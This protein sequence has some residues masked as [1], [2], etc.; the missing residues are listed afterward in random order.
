MLL[1][2]AEV[3]NHLKKGK[4]ISFKLPDG[5]FIPEYFHVTEIGKITKDFIDC[6]GTLRSQKV[7]NFQFWYSTDYNHRLHPK[8]LLHIIKL[9]K[10]KLHIDDGL[11]I[12]VEYQK[13][14]T[15][16]KYML[17]HDGI[18]FVLLTQRT[19]C[20]AKSDCSIESKQED[21]CCETSKVSCC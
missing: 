5:D 9:S 1:N 2:I 7:A 15:I 20:L 17:G 8:K 12:E 18:N 14:D 13:D 3:K 16:G 6:G 19:D 4:S 10:N 11:A 21:T